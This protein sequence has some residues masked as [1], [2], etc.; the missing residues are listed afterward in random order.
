MVRYPMIRQLW[1]R[2]GLV[3]GLIVLGLFKFWVIHTEEIYGSSAEYDALWYVGSA[4][5]WYWGATYSWTGFVRPCA[6]PLF[7]AIAHFCGVP[8]RIG[9]E[10]AQMMGSAALIA[11]LRKGGVPRWLC[12]LLF[13]LMILHPS[14]FLFNTHSMSESFYLAVLPLALAGSLFTLFTR[15]IFH[16]TWAGLAYAV[17][18]NIREESFL[19]PLILIVFFGLAW[20]QRREGTARKTHFVFWVKRFGALVAMMVLLITAIYSANYTAFHSF[21][22]SDLSS[23]PFEKLFKALLRIKPS[24]SLRYIAVNQEAL[25][26]AYTA[27]P[28]FAQLKP[29]FETTGQIWTDPVFRTF[30]IREYGPW[31]MWALRNVTATAGYYKDPVTTN[32]FYLQAAREINQACDEG[33][34]PSRFVLSSFLDPGAVSRIRYLPRSILKMA[35]LF[36]FRQQKVMVRADANLVP[37][38][39]DLYEEMVFRQPQAQPA[40][41][42]ETNAVII[43]N[44]ASAR[45][46]VAVQNFIGAYYVYLFIGLAWATLGAFLLLIWFFRRWHF[47]DPLMITMVLFATTIATRLLFFS[48]LDA[49]WWDGGYE[50]Y[51]VPVMP[52]TTGFFILMIY[53]AFVVCRKQSIQTK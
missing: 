3:L 22:K 29:H 41:H 9:I 25:R 44:S 37:W 30:G 40:L 47:T 43:S 13:S 16:A 26:L 33:R 12:L 31:F 15:K 7:I 28:T 36:L 2:Y 21:A 10:L 45:L 38:M 34:V 42:P 24:Y 14:S 19:I 5:Q 1:Q 46:A 49:T 27:S 4:K 52:L 20:W 32:N 18:W 8:L 50:R 35:K 23:P 11:A 48:F 53:E 39:S 6:Y 17:L 51:L